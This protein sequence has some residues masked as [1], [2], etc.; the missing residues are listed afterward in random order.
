MYAD[1]MYAYEMHACEMQ[2]YEMQACEMHARERDTPMRCCGGDE[3]PLTNNDTLSREVL[4][5]A[6]QS[7]LP[8]HKAYIN[9]YRITSFTR[10]VSTTCFGNGLGEVDTKWQ[11]AI[12]GI[13]PRKAPVGPDAPPPFNIGMT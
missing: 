11:L 9:E 3:N 6:P 5:G 13:C 2:T 7:H 4:F 12:L 1:E 8:F 10:L